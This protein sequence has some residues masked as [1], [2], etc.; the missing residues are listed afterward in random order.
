VT[1]YPAVVTG[2]NPTADLTITCPRCGNEVTERF[3][4]P[5]AACR[6]ELRSSQQRA[7]R[8]NI[9]VEYEPK[10]NVTPNAVALK[11]D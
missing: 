7:R 11:D 4:G 3:Y 6:S 10:M 5:C 2:S 9:G 1:K 8:E